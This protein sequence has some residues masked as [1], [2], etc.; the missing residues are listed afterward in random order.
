MGMW[1]RDE[2]FGRRLD[3]E[4]ALR[5]PFV[6][7]AIAADPEPLVLRETGETVDRAILT[8]RRWADGRPASESFDAKSTA[9]AIVK[10]VDEVEPGD[11]PALVELR[12]VAVRD[13]SNEALVIRLVRK[14]A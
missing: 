11:L 10:M 12:K 5:E 8:V 14:L 7:V 2:E 6:L 4:F 9:S 13:W 3:E 1:T